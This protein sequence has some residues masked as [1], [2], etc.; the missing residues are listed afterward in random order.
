VQR[1]GAAR[2]LAPV[3]E[4]AYRGDCGGWLL[5]HQPVPRLRDHQF[6]HIGR[7]SA[8]DDRHGRTERFLAADRQHRHCQL[9]LG[10]KGLV[11]AGVLV[12]RGELVEAGMHRTGLCVERGIVLA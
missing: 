4:G 10:D 8:H 11:V 7:G 5:L 1:G 6:L 3:E 2:R 12:E 9:P